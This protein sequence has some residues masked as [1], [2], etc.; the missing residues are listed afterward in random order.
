MNDI[1]EAVKK[2]R[3]EDTKQNAKIYIIIGTY[4]PLWII[5]INNY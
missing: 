4:V 2:I 5:K 3:I 1:L